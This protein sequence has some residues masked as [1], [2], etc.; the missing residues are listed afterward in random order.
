MSLISS[1]QIFDPLTNT[2]STIPAE[3]FTI[4]F[5]RNELANQIELILDYGQ[6]NIE[7]CAIQFS[8]DLSATNLTS[9][10]YLPKRVEN[11]IPLISD[12]TGVYLYGY[13]QETYAFQAIVSSISQGI[14]F[15]ALFMAVASFF[16]PFGKL[17]VI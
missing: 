3:S 9:L 1:I 14:G 4:K 12:K 11:F 8:I 2:T 13:D 5:S 17:I 15:L 7:E 10:K 16:M 6:Q